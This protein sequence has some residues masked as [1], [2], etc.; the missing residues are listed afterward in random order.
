VT[1]S[2]GLIITSR[3]AFRNVGTYATHYVKGS[4]KKH[5][6]PWTYMF[7]RT[8]NER[9]YTKLFEA[10]KRYAMEFFDVD[11]NLSF[12][13]LDRTPYIANAYRNVWPGI[14]LLSCYTHLLKNAREHRSMLSSREFYDSDFVVNL[15]L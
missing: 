13:S 14:K 1:S 9:S 2:F 3:H 5:F 4:Y 10:T 11:L 15:N 6:V 7:V 12:G 8:E